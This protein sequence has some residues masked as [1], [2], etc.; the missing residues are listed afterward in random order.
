MTTWIRATD[1]S[2]VNA[3]QLA[4]VFITPEVNNAVPPALTGLYHIVGQV[5]AE[6]VSTIF[7]TVGTEEV[8]RAALERLSIEMISG[9]SLLVVM[10]HLMDAAEK[11]IEEER[12]RAV[13]RA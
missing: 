7:L 8:C 2:L 1:G 12:A 11:S 13:D 3:D 9:E 4:Q 5:P 10:E 6:R